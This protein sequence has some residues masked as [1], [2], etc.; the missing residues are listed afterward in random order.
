MHKFG[1]ELKKL[2]SQAL[3][4]D[5]KTGKDFCRKEIENQMRNNGIDLEIMYKD[6]ND[7][8]GYQWIDWNFL[9]VVSMNVQRKYH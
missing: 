2:A 9:F 1:I 7:T 3:D 8:I 5:K 4:I 6:G